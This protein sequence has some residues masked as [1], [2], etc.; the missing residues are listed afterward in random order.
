MFFRVDRYSVLQLSVLRLPLRMNTDTEGPFHK[1]LEML[2]ESQAKIN[3]TFSNK[4]TQVSSR[5]VI[6]KLKHYNIEQSKD[7]LI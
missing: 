4:E 5:A 3:S 1:R 6:L 7:I 2:S